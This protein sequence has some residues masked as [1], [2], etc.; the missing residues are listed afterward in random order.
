MGPGAKG[1]P[2]RDIP[3]L[4]V[5]AIY[6]FSKA[7]GLI[8]THF[9]RSSYQTCFRTL[10]FFTF[11]FSFVQDTQFLYCHFWSFGFRTSADEAPTYLS[12]FSVTLGRFVP[13]TSF[14]WS[15]RRRAYHDISIIDL[16]WV[17]EVAP[18]IQI[19]DHS[20]TSSSSIDIACPP[21]CTKAARL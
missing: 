5:E 3:R 9:L 8:A 13:D 15:A 19:C 18:D 6:Q 7:Q 10:L 2:A 17:L 1:M 4:V 11:I 14:I 21:V 20:E 12:C 16:W